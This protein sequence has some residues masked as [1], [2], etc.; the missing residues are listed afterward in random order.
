MAATPFVLTKDQDTVKANTLSLASYLL[1]GESVA[2][3]VLANLQPVTVPALAVAVGTVTASTVSVTATGGKYTTTYGARLTVTTSSARTFNVTVAVHVVEDLKLL[4]KTHN[5]DAYQNLINEIESGDA[6]VGKVFFTFPAA[7]SF[8]GSSVRW[9]LLDEAGSVF[10]TGNA[11][12]Y[13]VTSTSMKAT[14]EAMAVIHVPSNV[15]PSLSGYKYQIRWEL[16]NLPGATQPVYS[17]ESITVLGKTTAPQGVRDS[18]ELQGDRAEL[19]IVLPR[20]FDEIGIEVFNG[21]TSVVPFTPASYEATIDSGYYFQV[22][23]E[24]STITSQLDPYIV[25][26][27]YRNTG[28]LTNRESGKLFVVNPSI[29]DAIDDCRQRLMKAHTTLMQ[30]DDIL[31][32][33]EYILSGLRRGRDAFNAAAGVLTYFDMTNATGGIREYWLRFAEVHMLRAQYLAEG[34][35]SFDFQGQA[36]SLST[37]KAQY[38]QGL[39]DNIQQQLDNDIKPFKQNLAKRGIISGDGDL[40]NKAGHVSVGRTGIGMHPMSIYPF[41]YRGFRRTM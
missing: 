16:S 20:I 9:S 3:V 39:A 21:N 23:L 7:Q 34:E 32:A 8:T 27:R 12:E 37:D 5:L 26:W 6:A 22:P 29:L 17:F 13:K 2:S 31:F 28:G 36:I 10:S 24:T 14:L 41:G 4:N 25:T 38:Y 19:S 15:S 1:S 11:Y 18:V 40:N 30:F 35:K 33:D